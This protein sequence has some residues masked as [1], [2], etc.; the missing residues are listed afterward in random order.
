MVKVRLR[1]ERMSDGDVVELDSLDGLVA[2]ES[3][4]TV[5]AKL[6]YLEKVDED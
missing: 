4:G 3:T 1:V 5:S 2:I 6:F